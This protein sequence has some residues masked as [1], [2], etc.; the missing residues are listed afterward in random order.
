MTMHFEGTC[1]YNII[2]YRYINL[3]WPVPETFYF[4]S[5]IVR[6]AFAMF[7]QFCVHLSL[8]ARVHTSQS[9][10]RFFYLTF[11]MLSPFFQSEVPEKRR[12]TTS[13]SKSPGQRG[14]ISLIISNI[15]RF[16]SLSYQQD[17]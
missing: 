2:V 7:S 3:V 13:N 8:T 11:R 17:M 16:I 10:Y 14:I 6:S 9:V 12:I 4:P 5:F 15:T 1:M